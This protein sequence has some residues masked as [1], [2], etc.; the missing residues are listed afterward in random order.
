[1]ATQQQNARVRL[2]NDI[3]A[4]WKKATSFIPK[5]GE[6]IIYNAEKNTDELPADRT[7]YIKYPRFKVGDGTTNVN[8][9]PF[10]EQPQSYLAASDDGDGYITLENCTISFIEELEKTI[11]QFTI[12]GTTYTAESGMTWEEWV[13]SSYNTD[14]YFTGALSNNNDVYK[15]DGQ[16]DYYIKESY[17]GR[18]TG[19][20]DNIIE[21]HNYVLI[22]V[23]GGSHD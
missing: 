23:L 16:F 11:I 5:Q 1:M 18:G 19:Y 7:Y 17:D 6:L 20:T 8:N 21:N 2:K 14:G 9:L 13:N 15:A 10:F 12:D 4:N 3:E 22:P